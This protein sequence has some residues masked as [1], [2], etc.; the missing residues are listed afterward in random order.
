M[1]FTVERI[2]DTLLANR[3][4]AE[5]HDKKWHRENLDNWL[6]DLCSFLYGGSSMATYG[7]LRKCGFIPVSYSSS[8][9]CPPDSNVFEVRIV[10]K[11]EKY[12]L[13]SAQYSPEVTLILYLGPIT[14]TNTEDECITQVCI[15][16]ESIQYKP[17][18]N[19]TMAQITTVAPSGDLDYE[20]AFG[21]MN[22][23]TR[24]LYS[25][26]RNRMNEHRDVRD[27]IRIDTKIAH[28]PRKF[29]FNFNTEFYYGKN[30]VKR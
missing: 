29:S 23:M 22:D 11:N 14:P 5:K 27:L 21:T 24:T 28:D 15:L 3:G 2:I 10:M 8:L 7:E 17:R 25:I 6:T 1:A 9:V 30:A 13:V 18:F 4:N 12:K 16:G 20:E 26:V 19:S